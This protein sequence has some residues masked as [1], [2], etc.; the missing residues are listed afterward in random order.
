MQKLPAPKKQ[1]KQGQPGKA[2]GSEPT[3]GKQEFWDLVARD[4]WWTGDRARKHTKGFFSKA[5]LGNP[6]GLERDLQPWILSNILVFALGQNADTT[7]DRQI[8]AWEEEDRLSVNA[9]AAARSASE[10]REARAILDREE[11]QAVFPG[12]SNLAPLLPAAHHVH[13]QWAAG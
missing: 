10:L 3:G 7:L 4:R 2:G 1:K 9:G 5:R 8:A 11:A 12:A 13:F 6:L